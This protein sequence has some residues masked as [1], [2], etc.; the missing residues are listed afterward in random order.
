MRDRPRRD[1]RILGMTI[2]NRTNMTMEPR[3]LRL[4]AVLARYSLSRSTLYDLMRKGFPKPIHLGRSS[5]W[6][7][8][9]LLTHEQHCANQREG[10]IQS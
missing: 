4:P 8:D 10:T 1:G 6:A 3:Y 2:T 5:L 9:E 7:V